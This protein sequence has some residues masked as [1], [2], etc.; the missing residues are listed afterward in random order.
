MK[1]FSA[2]GFVAAICLYA[3]M[4]YLTFIFPADTGMVILSLSGIVAIVCAAINLSLRSFSI[5]LF[6][7]T[8]ATVVQLVSGGPLGAFFIDGIVQMRS[9]ITLLLIVPV[10]GW[11]LREEPYIDSIMNVAHN[12][13]DSSKKFYFGVMIVNQII[14]YFLLFGSIPMMYQFINEFLRNKKS[15][16]W[17]YFKGTALLRS[18]ALTTLWVVS[19]PSFAFAVDHLDAS[20][21]GTIAQGFFISMGGI[22]LAVWFASY[23][24]KIY[25]INFTAGIKEEIDRLVQNTEDVK[26]SKRHVMEFACL[27][28]SL[29]STIFILHITMGWGL[30]MVIPP[31]ILVWTCA[32]FLVK[33]RGDRLFIQAKDYFGEEMKYKSQQFSLLLAAGMLIF[34]VNQSGIGN[35]LVDSLFYLEEVVPFLNFLVIL[36]FT[37]IFLGFLG[38]GPLT[39]IVLV[40]GILQNVSLPYPAEL[41]V[42]SMT[43]G[44]VIS[45]L[46]SPVILP[47]IILSATNG[48]SILKNGFSFNLGY[49][50]A[51]YLFVQVYIQFMWYVVY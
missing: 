41:V 31:V 33:R 32:Y 26:Q 37:V 1:K 20:L 25:G 18:F 45:V 49:S 38:L 11:I 5:P 7:L 4:H 15:E 24:E 35:Y 46:L 42:L 8:A 2:A 51:F 23:K 16:A 47:I 40:A 6:L 12:L 21:A 14:A 28:V 17:E 22:L 27:F 50:I 29:F 10:I 43:S 39:V 44:S 34:S 3:I 30:L 48:L 19:I 9:L 36:P 13:L